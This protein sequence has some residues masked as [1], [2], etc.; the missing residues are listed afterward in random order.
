MLT[1][2]TQKVVASLPSSLQDLLGHAGFQ[3][4]FKNTS[5]MLA[6]RMVS[7]AVSFFVVGFVAQYLGPVR[8]GT[9]SYAQSFVAILSVLASL[10]IDQI[11][12]RDLVA[13][14]EQENVLLGTAVYMKLAFGVSAFFITL[15]A[16]VLAQTDSLTTILI[17]LIA[18]TF[19]LQPLG[20]VSHYLNAKVLSKQ[21]SIITIFL[22]FFLSATKVV[23]VLSKAPLVYFAGVLLLESLVYA[24]FYFWIYEK[25]SGQGIER[26]IFS[27]PVAKRLL[28][29]GWPL[30]LA[31]LFGYIYGRID[32]VMLGQMLGLGA[33]GIYDAAVRISEVWYFLPGMIIGSLFPAIINA[34]NTD[35]ASYFR[36]LRALFSFVLLLSLLISSLIFVF[37]SPLMHLVFGNQFAESIGV[38]R[39]YVWA[40]IGMTVGA[41]AQQYLVAE[42]YGKIF[43]YVSFGTALLNIILNFLFIP[44][45]GATGAAIATLVSYSLIPLSLLVFPASRKDISHVFSSAPITPSR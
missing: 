41:L 17:A 40:G 8:F 20:I 30:M 27:L 14:P 29:D 36:R 9:L 3:K 26:W 18:L 31:S 12:Y 28:K 32:Q 13:L 45:Y 4:Y 25:I 11:L 15:L 37:A 35:K 44:L 43:F 34:R 6:A 7:L 1:I 38:V 33:V 23:L 16:A 21:N 24:L 39:I 42:N 22:A 5:W 19:L 2:F 10:G